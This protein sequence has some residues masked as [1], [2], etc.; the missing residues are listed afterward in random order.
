S[1]PPEK[2]LVLGLR[3]LKEHMLKDPYP[4]S[5]EIISELREKQIWLREKPSPSDG[6]FYLRDFVDKWVENGWVEKGQLRNRY[7]ITEKGEMI[8]NIFYTDPDFSI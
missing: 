1:N 8:L 2:Y 3:I 5:K 6:V 7:S 4:P